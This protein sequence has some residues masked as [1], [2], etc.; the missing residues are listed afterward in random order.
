MP[1]EQLSD[2]QVAAY[3]HLDLR[4]V[5]KL[6]SRDRLPCRKVGGRFLFTK[7]EIDRWVEEQI[8]ELDADRLERIE[9]GVRAHHGMDAEGLVVLPLIPEGGLAAPLDARTRDAALRRLVDLAVECGRVY[10]P[11]DVLE[12]VRGR[13][14][15]C[16]TAVA[17]GVALPHP[18][19]PLP[20]DVAESFVVAGLTGAGIPFGAPDG[21]L[22]RLFFLVCCKEER[23]QLHV[24]A[25]LAR[26]VDS[27]DARAAVM[28]AAGPAELRAALLSRERRLV[29]GG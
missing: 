4:E 24:L 20:Y 6:A 3:L 29:G 8:H 14:D 10:A 16:S 12:D 2:Q 23:T 26:M 19:G 28:N 15:L 22:T 9:R 7:A 5:Q 27:A 11:E 13:E 21:S 18:P 25:R 1:Y 17:P